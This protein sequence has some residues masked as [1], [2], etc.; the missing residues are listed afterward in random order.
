MSRPPMDRAIRHP[1]GSMISKGEWSLI[2]ATAHLILN[3]DLLHLKRRG[4]PSKHNKAPM[5]GRTYFKSYFPR[6]WQSAVQ[7]LEQLQPLM[8]LCASHWKAESLLGNLSLRK[9]VSEPAP[10]ADNDGDMDVDGWPS[11]G[12]PN[13]DADSAPEQSSTSTSN[14]RKR[15]QLPVSD[16]RLGAA[17]R[18]KGA[19]AAQGESPQPNTTKANILHSAGFLATPLELASNAEPPI[20]VKYIKV[21]FT[22]TPI[23][24]SSQLLYVY[25][26]LYLAVGNLRGKSLHFRN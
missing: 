11:G 14:S 22:S 12:E 23:H 2:V 18:R 5:K 6:E 3:D 26:S 7:K 1:D 24:Y 13:P 15:Q 21:N 20:D 10:Q 8:A 19:V 17:K 16:S 4:A 25:S 9:K